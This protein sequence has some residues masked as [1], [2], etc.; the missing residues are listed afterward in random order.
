VRIILVNFTG[1]AREVL[2]KGCNGMLKVMTFSKDNFSEAAINYRWN[3][4]NNE[5]S[6]HSGKPMLLE[7]WSVT[8]AEGW[9]KQ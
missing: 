4:E 8:F 1:S 3:C 2:L 7:P 5:K 9:R 6:W